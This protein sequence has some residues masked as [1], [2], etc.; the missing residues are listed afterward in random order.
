MS[1]WSSSL[2][3]AASFVCVTTASVV[4][5]DRP[6]VVLVMVD[7]MGHSDL[8]CYGSEIDTPNLDRLADEGLRFTQFDNCAKCETTQGVLRQL[9]T[10]S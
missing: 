6:N 5:D 2:L 7:D 9:L 4:A 8:G 1:H 10:E 3:V